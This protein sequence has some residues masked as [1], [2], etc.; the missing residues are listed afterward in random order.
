MLSRLNRKIKPHGN[1]KIKKNYLLRISTLEG[2]KYYESFSAFGI[3]TIRDYLLLNFRGDFS[4]PGFYTNENNNRPV[5]IGCFNRLDD[6][7]YIN[8]ND[9]IEH[10]IGID[11]KQKKQKIWEKVY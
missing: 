7:T 9:D 1:N 2:K 3:D 4:A 8:K 6:D 5:Q 10:I 11:V